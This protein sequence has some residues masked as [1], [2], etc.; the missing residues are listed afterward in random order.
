MTDHTEPGARATSH[1][2]D[3]DCR[4]TRPDDFYQA[5]IDAHQGL[6]DADSHRMN[7]RLVL[8][9]ANQVGDMHVLTQALVRS[10]DGLEACAPASSAG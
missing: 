6:S 9:L 4:L 8:L 7:A 5:L 2:L 10:R 1:G 3:T